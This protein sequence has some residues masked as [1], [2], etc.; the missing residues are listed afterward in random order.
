MS[1]PKVKVQSTSIKPLLTL[2]GYFAALMAVFFVSDIAFAAS[3]GGGLGEVAKT[4][5]ESMGN[6][7]KLIAAASYVAGIGFAL[8]GMMKFKAHKDQPQQVPLS[9]P[10]T[11]IAIAAGL[12]FLPSIIKAAGSTLFGG[13][14]KTAGEEGELQIK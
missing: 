9:Q 3:G 7:A 8:S 12:I 5:Q 6:V 4:V 2:A 10:I 1:D 11:L 14:A 13:E